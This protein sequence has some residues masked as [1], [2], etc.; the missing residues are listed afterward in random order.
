MKSDKKAG[1]I[2][3]ARMTSTRLPGKILKEVEGKSM[4][5][6]HINRLRWSDIPIYIATTTNQTD[7]LIVEFAKSHGVAFSRGS[8]ENVLTRYYECARQNELDIVIRVTSDCPLIDGYQIRQGLNKYLEMSDENLYI[9]NG[10]ERTYPRGFDF[11]IFSF[12]LLEDAYMHADTVPELEHVTPYIRSNRSGKVNL[13]NIANVV[14]HGGLRITLDTPEDFEL[15]SK[16]IEDFDA[17]KLGYEKITEILMSH[18]ELVRIN[19]H[20]EQ[21]KV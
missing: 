1:I 4:L 11:E 16:L 8:E 21:K 7:D 6:Y 20:V 3:Q 2:T 13:Y 9:S 5:E 15:I 14:N 17:D 10:I 12:R 18:P 19:A